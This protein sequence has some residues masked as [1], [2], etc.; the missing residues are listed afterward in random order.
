MPTRKPRGQELSLEV[1]LTNQ[2]LHHRRL[3]IEHVN[4]SVKRC[5]I[6]KDRLRLWKQGIHDRVMEICCALHLTFKG[7]AWR[8]GNFFHYP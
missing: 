6:V 4:S 1:K 3:R 5:R 2:A 7:V 8:N